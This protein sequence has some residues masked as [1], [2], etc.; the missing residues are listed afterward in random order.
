MLA[1]FKEHHVSIILLPSLQ[2]SFFHGYLYIMKEGIVALLCGYSYKA[3]LLRPPIVLGYYIIRNTNHFF[4]ARALRNK[5]CLSHSVL[6]TMQLNQNWLDTGESRID[7]AFFKEK[8][9]EIWNQIAV[10][11]SL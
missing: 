9:L 1:M 7:F 2:T 5:T 3:N 8:D 11:H 10:K 4:H 6:T